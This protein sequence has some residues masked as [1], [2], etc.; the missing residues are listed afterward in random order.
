MKYGFLN[1]QEIIA[2]THPYIFNDRQGFANYRHPFV[3]A[4]IGVASM[5]KQSFYFYQVA[6]EF[7]NEILNKEIE[8]LVIG[9]NENIDT[10]YINN[11]VKGGD[12][13]NM[14]DRTTFEGKIQK[15]HYAIFFYDEIYQLTGSG[16]VLDAIN[17]EKPILAFENELFKSIFEKAGKIGYLCKDVEEMKIIIR[18][19]LSGKITEDEYNNFRLNMQRFKR[20]NSLNNIREKLFSQISAL[21]NKD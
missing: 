5:E 19:I 20:D 13:K 21:Y 17:F 9:R 3:M 6:K 1:E 7:E 10:A 4:H 2:I 12:S 15:A 11:F 18:N 14:L 16:A 8:F